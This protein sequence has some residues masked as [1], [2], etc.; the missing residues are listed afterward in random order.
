MTDSVDI[1]KAAELLGRTERQIRFMCTKGT[2]SGAVKNGNRW[3]IPITA[4]PKLNIAGDSQE[5]LNSAELRNVPAN[6]RQEALQR[7]GILQDF[8]KF[9]AEFVSNSGSRNEAFTVYAS[10]HETSKRTLERWNARYREQGLIGLVDMRGGGKF[11]SRMIS[12]EAFEVFKSMYLTQQQL[13]IKTCWQNICYIN[14]SEDKG[15][16]VPPLHFMYRYVKNH[17]PLTVQILHR[18]GLAAYE[19]RCAP[20]IQTDPDSI[21]PGQVWVGDHSQ[22]NCW[23]RY[24]GKWIRPW[25]TAW[26]DMRS[27]CIV[28]LH[29]NNSPNQTTILLAMKRAIEKYGPPD[30]VKIDNGKD[31][32]SEC[33]TGTTK[34]RRRAL[35]AGYLD[36]KMVAGIYAMMGVGISFSIKYHPQSKRIERWFDTL[37][38]Q[39][40]KTLP[41]YCGKDTERKPD[42]LNDLLKSEKQ[43]HQAHSL[44]SFTALVGKYI[45]AYNNSAHTGSGME[46]KS[47]AQVLATRS[48][49]RIM[50]EGVLDL[51]L[52]VWS[53]EL[54]VSKN[55]VRFH[56]IWY[57]QF[58]TDLLMLQGKK[59]RLSYDPDDLRT[60]YVYDAT[61]LK[62]LT[63]AEQ[64]QLIR[65][66]S[67]VS[68]ESFREAVRQKSR[69]T[70]IVRQFCDSQLTAYTDLAS[71][72][73]KAMQEGA[74]EAAQPPAAAIKTLRPVRTPFDGQVA[75]H[76]RREIL[77]AVKKAAGAESIEKVLDFDFSELTRK[78]ERG[79]LDL[80]GG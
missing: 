80:F 49:Q 27:R 65:Y 76:G 10:Q 62:L 6:K 28:G 24:R 53:G 71:L 39:F 11:I 21:V 79:S 3:K 31:Y 40:T 22:L 33:W 19:A 51:L 50:A 2:L 12:P 37:D 44:E 68:E 13:G 75:E 54:T 15:W 36:E 52:R 48:S 8:K 9:A 66:G 63:I 72:T 32:D 30:S 77:K 67:P 35:K 78:Q 64:N 46:G 70:K 43:I 58:N 18:E 7:L 17:I 14:R 1:K 41:T 4:H 29:I 20:Y 61:T 55:G 73:I 42:Y 74:K 57:G 34:A 59:V 38:C 23:I 25:I 16:K 45:E 26:L 47:P 56:G 5:L 69:A 60:V